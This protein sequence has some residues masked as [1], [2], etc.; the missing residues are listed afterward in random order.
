MV[1]EKANLA[2]A[3]TSAA[4]TLHRH[5]G[6]GMLYELR[7]IDAWRT[8]GMWEWNASYFIEDGIYISFE[9]TTR[10]LLKFLR[11][12]GWLNDWSKGRVCVV[13]EGDLIEIQLK[14]THE[15][16]LALMGQYGEVK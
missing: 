7:S 15:P 12:N 13:D 3:D 16:I 14:G 6:E 4:V 1:I 2:D 9:S 5:N 8:S 11:R 10:T